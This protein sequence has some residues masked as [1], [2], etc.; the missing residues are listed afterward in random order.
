MSDKNSIDR[1]DLDKKL[2]P[3]N[4]LTKV[5]NVINALFSTRYQSNTAKTVLGTILAIQP[6]DSGGSGGETREVVVQR[7]ADDMLS[8]VP[9]NYISYEVGT[10]TGIW[11]NTDPI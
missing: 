8:K 7:L 10:S 3:T 5:P 2:H 1:L 11:N 6:K 9:E 4:E